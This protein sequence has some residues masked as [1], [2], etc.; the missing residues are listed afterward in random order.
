MRRAAPV[1]RPPHLRHVGA[2]TAPADEGVAGSDPLLARQHPERRRL[3]GAV[4][5]EQS[6][7]FALVDAD[8][9][10]RRGKRRQGL[11]FPSPSEPKSDVRGE[12]SL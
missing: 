7:T 12:C 1:R 4:R 9:Q 6:E 8:R 3:A 5:A 11:S 2:E 10:L